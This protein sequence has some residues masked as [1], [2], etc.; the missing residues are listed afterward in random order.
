MKIVFDTNVILSAFL[1]QGLSSRILDICLDLHEIIISPWIEN[2][3]IEKLAN[4]FKASKKEL[5]RVV[6]FL[7]SEFKIIN[8]QGEIP[9]IC[10]DK[11]DNNILYI[12]ESQ[13]VD[14][15]ITGDK[16]LLELKEYLK[17]KIINPRD[18]IEQ[19]YKKE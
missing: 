10:R 16:D 14:L 9:N 18:F 13:D 5:E 17:I 3:V 8:P 7:H 6:Y 19:Y 2:E 12:A 11:D 15:I 4:K 1:T